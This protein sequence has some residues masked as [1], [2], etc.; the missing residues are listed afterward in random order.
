MLH[1]MKSDFKVVFLS[2]ILVF[3]C[4]SV[5]ARIVNISKNVSVNEGENVNLYCLAVGRPEPTVTWKDQKCK[6]PLLVCSSLEPQ[7]SISQ[8]TALFF[9]FTSA[10]HPISIQ[11]M[12]MSLSPIPV[13]SFLNPAV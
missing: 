13:S 8:L 1:Q 5:P 11:L 9:F 2:E 12:S 4:F 3:A 6:P 7:I 10:H